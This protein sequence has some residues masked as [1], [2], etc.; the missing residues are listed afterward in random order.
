M[1]ALVACSTG[2]TSG[3]EDDD[4]SSTGDDDDSSATGDDDTTGGGDDDTTGGGDDDDTGGGGDDDDSAAGDDDDGCDDPITG[5]VELDSS[6]SSPS[7]SPD[8]TIFVFPS[9]SYSDDGLP[10]GAPSSSTSGPHSGTFPASFD[11]CGVPG[12]VAVVAFLDV[13]GDGKPCTPDDY[14]GFTELE[15]ASGGTSG[16][17]ITLDRVLVDGD[18]GH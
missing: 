6:L 8:L 14:H 16:V 4:D 15:I 9:G 7:G 3:E 11:A 17:T 2:R 13:G 10:T 18:C 5:T 12:D 1:V